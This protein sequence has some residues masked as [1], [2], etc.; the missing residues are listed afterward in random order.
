MIKTIK[1]RLKRI[2]FLKRIVRLIKKYFFSDPKII[3]LLLTFDMYA[4]NSDGN[5]RLKSK[6]TKNTIIGIFDSINQFCKELND[7]KK[8]ILKVE[9]LNINNEEKKSI[10]EL[11]LLLNKYG[12]DKAYKHQYHILYGKI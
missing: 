11:K 5:P 2:V 10:E 9:D 1:E 6:L 8:E 3:S 7:S 12:S 4:P